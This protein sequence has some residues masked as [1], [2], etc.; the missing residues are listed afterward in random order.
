MH[1]CGNQGSIP[2]H[3]SSHFLKITYC[4]TI[5]PRFNAYL[6]INVDLILYQ[7]NFSLL[8]IETVT[9]TTKKKCRVLEPRVIR[10]INQVLL[11][12]R[13]RSGRSF[14]TPRVIGLKS[15]L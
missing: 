14:A 12:L 8:N 7:E 10:D 5:F 9:K 11:N 13:I 4:L 2:E 15:L 6:E 3:D 1:G